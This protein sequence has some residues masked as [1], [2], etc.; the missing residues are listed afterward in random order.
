MA[1]ASEPKNN[2]GNG[3][4]QEIPRPDPTRMYGLTHNLDGTPIVRQVRFLK[5]GFGVPVGKD[6]HVWIGAD[7]RWNIELGVYEAR[8]ANGKQ[9]NKRVAPKIFYAE[10]REV[11]R[12][13]Y[14][15]LWKTAPARDFPRKLPYFTFLRMGIDGSFYPDFEAIED[16]G[17]MPTEIDIIFLKDN[18]LEAS[19]QWWTTAELKCEGDG[20]NARRR[21]DKANNSPHEQG[22]VKEA[23]ARGERFFPIIEGCFTSGC[24]FAR[25]ERPV[26]KPHG[27]LAL[28]LLKSS[29]LRIGGTVTYDTTGWRSVSQLFSCIQEIRSMTGRGHVEDG[30]IA[31]I[32]L[33]MVLRPFRASHNGQSS[34]Q[35]AVSLEFRATAEAAG[36]VQS[37]LE[38]ADQF[39]AAVQL[40]AP[41]AEP[42][43]LGAG[44]QWE[45]EDD[46]PESELADARALNAE[47][48]GDFKDQPSADP[49]T[50]PWKVSGRPP[51]V[52]TTG[53]PPPPPQNSNSGIS[54]PT[55]N[56]AAAAPAPGP[57][58][59][60]DPEK[61]TAKRG[62]TTRKV[63][64]MPASG[65]FNIAQRFGV[66]K[67]EIMALTN[68]DDNPYRA[69]LR[70]Y[71][72][73]KSTHIPTE[74]KAAPIEAEIKQLIADLKAGVSNT[75]TAAAEQKT[76]AKAET[77]TAPATSDADLER[78]KALVAQIEGKLAK[79]GNQPAAV[80]AEA[81][82]AFMRGYLGIE[83]LRAG[84]HP[85]YEMPLWLLCRMA[86]GA[87]FAKQIMEDGN[88]FGKQARAGFN[89]FSRY[90]EDRGSWPDDVRLIVRKVGMERY[91]E[92]GGADAM[93]FL[94]DVAQ[95]D[96]GDGE[97]GSTNA[98][99]DTPTL[100]TFIQV[101]AITP[102]VMPLIEESAK[103][104]TSIPDLVLAWGL[105]LKT[106]SREQVEAK[107]GKG[108]F[109]E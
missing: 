86:G 94:N 98:G 13:Q 44:P 58:P 1:T 53:A 85:D 21:F 22:L 72:F 67:K 102:N 88:N 25:G 100:R 103:T 37:L 64:E 105:D 47:F 89:E 28:Q 16:H 7:G 68:G 24:E 46:N 108:I 83:K 101:W 106:A 60:P 23:Q 104:G 11:A 107:M 66:L 51:E 99:M 34:M 26:C 74:E 40:P 82:R 90:L 3:A 15:E 27:R 14:A 29:E 36:L 18:P 75:F 32:P 30:H 42:R 73:E 97:A 95:V 80:I 20:L 62:T 19:Y 33:K 78:Q 71:K 41:T 17:P 6:L 84:A 2:G 55:P 77:T 61:T 63:Q 12:E 48:Y 96:G 70:K 54:T 76:E 39:R 43:L 31:G 59:V 52:M 65:N 91:P 8:T 50:N 87:L 57:V 45:E 35:Y 109:D 56:G 69:I 49:P 9:F 93:M 10:N 81:R 5:V 92:T 4:A 38:K 79:W